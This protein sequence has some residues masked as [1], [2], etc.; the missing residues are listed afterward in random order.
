MNLS[1]YTL[2]RDRIDRNVEGIPRTG[3]VGVVERKEASNGETLLS[4]KITYL[5]MK[6]AVQASGCAPI[7][8]AFEEGKEKATL[9]ENAH[10]IASGIRVPAAIGDFLII[11]AVKESGGFALAVD[12]SDIE[13]AQTEVAKEEGMS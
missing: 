7:V 1:S 6:V 8:K 9:W 2:S 12:D 11:R 10:T 3:G 13:A 4:I 5:Y